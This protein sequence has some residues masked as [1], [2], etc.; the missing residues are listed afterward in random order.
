MEDPETALLGVK[1]L[2]EAAENGSD[3]ALQALLSIADRAQ[4]VA[5][6]VALMEVAFPPDKMDDRRAA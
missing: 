2:L 6:N 4:A 1:M 3:F 5:K